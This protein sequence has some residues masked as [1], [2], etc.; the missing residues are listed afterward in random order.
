M[1]TSP[2]RAVVIAG[3]EIHTIPTVGS[4]ALV[5]AADSGYDHALSLNIEVDLLIGDLDSISPKGLDHARAHRVEMIKFPRDKDNTDLELAL[6]AAMDRDAVAVEIHGGEGGTIAHL[7]GVA[8]ST[9]HRDLH[10]IDV[11]WHTDTGAVRPATPDRS[12]VA[13]VEVGDAITIIP[14][15]DVRGVTASGLRWPLENASMERGTTRGI[16]N[17]ATAQTVEVAVE[18]GAL[19]V[20]QEHRAS[21]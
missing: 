21:R 13:S 5:I 18:E 2:T 7:L 10:A 20:I 4:D 11:A 19:L 17:E 8:L 3:G 15:G 9:T 12:V 16:S 6:R 14:M 1:T